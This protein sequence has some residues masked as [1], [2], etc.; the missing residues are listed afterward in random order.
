MNSALALAKFLALLMISADGMLV[1]M[2]QSV[3]IAAA[4]SVEDVMSPIF[5]CLED[6]NDCTEV[7][8]DSWI[9][10]WAMLSS[11]EAFLGAWNTNAT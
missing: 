10:C 4:P 8:D 2:E 9:H 1:M 11:G 3:S 6:E 7:D 5:P